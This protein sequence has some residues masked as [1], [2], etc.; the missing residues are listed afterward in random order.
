MTHSMDER[1]QIAKDRP[2]RATTRPFR[3]KKLLCRPL[4][5]G[6]HSVVSNSIQVR[7]YSFFFYITF[8]INSINY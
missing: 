2:F 8:F 5:V 1:S 3:A 7:V 4:M 6:T